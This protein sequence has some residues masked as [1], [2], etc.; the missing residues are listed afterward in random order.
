MYPIFRVKTN[1]AFS[2]PFSAFMR[3]TFCFVTI[4]MKQH[5]TCVLLLLGTILKNSPTHYFLDQKYYDFIAHTHT[6][7]VKDVRRRK[8]LNGSGVTFAVVEKAGWVLLRLIKTTSNPDNSST[9]QYIYNTPHY[10][11][12]VV[13]QNIGWC[14]MYVSNVSV[15]GNGNESCNGTVFPPKRKLL[16]YA[17]SVLGPLLCS[18]F[19]AY[20]Y[21]SHYVFDAGHKSIRPKHFHKH[22]CERTQ[23][24]YNVM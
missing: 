13:S 3:H 24:F 4:T 11:Y 17:V 16:T 2:K 14:S 8:R 19:D 10:K 5:L 12:S 21:F 6:L 18:Y 23:D 9:F 20:L 15:F 22:F 7:S 1:I